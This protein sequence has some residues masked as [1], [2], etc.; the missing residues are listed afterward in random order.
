MPISI[1]ECDPRPNKLLIQD[2]LVI[3]QQLR[4][5]VSRVKDDIAYLKQKQLESEEAKSGWIW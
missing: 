4:I 3:L 1:E 5:D 2:I